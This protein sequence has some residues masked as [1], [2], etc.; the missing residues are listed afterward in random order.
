MTEENSSK[1]A[2]EE[3]TFD[4]RQLLKLAV[5]L[6]PLVVFFVVNSRAGIFWGTG[7]FVVATIVSL[8]ASRALFGRIPTMPFI[9]G[10]FVVVFGGLTLLLQDE[11]FIKLKPTIVNGIF[12][13]MLFGGLLVGKPV[14]KYMFGEVFRLTEE[15]WRKLTLRWACFFLGLALLNEVV[16]RHFSTDTWVS[17]KVF[18]VMPLTMIFALAQIGLLKRYE[19]ASS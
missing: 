7:C 11:L 4:S 12:A 2:A 8:A 14:M 16:W 13:A 10:I 5:E 3:P 1:P 15:G 9:T 19:Q 6:G 17:F 18:G